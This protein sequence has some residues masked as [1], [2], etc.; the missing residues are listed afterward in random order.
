V[1]VLKIAVAD[2]GNSDLCLLLTSVELNVVVENIERFQLKEEPDNAN[3]TGSRAGMRLNSL[4][5]GTIGSIWI[6]MTMR[7]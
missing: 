6:A 2:F 5:A 3:R 1:A 7:S 4:A